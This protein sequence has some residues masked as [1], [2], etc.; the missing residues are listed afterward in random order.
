MAR[1]PLSLPIRLKEE[2]EE[3]AAR[4]G[5]S[6]NQ[7]ILWSVAEKVGSL[8]QSLDDPA[9]PRVTYRRGAAGQ[10]VPVLQGTG[11]RVQTVVVAAQQWGMEAGQIATEFGL[12]EAQ[13]KEAVAFYAAHQ[14]EIDAALAAER[15]LEASH[16]P[17]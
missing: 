14:A 13:V 7:F 12:L 15:A 11:I 9:F 3:L 16:G 5:V 8:R 6:L 2:A 17:A 1:Y 4:Q 10:P